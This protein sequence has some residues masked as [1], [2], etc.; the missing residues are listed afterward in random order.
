MTD[1]TKELAEALPPLP[2][3]AYNIDAGSGGSIPGYSARQM[4]SYA[5]FALAAY[6]ASQ[7]AITPET[8]NAA[9]LRA[10]AITPENGES[11]DAMDAAPLAHVDRSDSVNLARNMLEVH[12]CKGITAAGVRILCEGVLRMDAALAAQHKEK[13]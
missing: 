11:A 9:A 3:R 8:G 12:D 6:R 13:A 7:Q 2:G 4:R 1:Y 5:L 10:S